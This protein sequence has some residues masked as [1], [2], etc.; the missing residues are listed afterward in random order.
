MKYLS[1]AVKEILATDDIAHYYLVKMG[2]FKNAD[3]DTETM[4]HTHVSGGITIGD[5]YY[6][7]DNTLTHVDPPRQSAAVDRENFKIMYSDPEFLYRGLFEKGFSG[8]PVEIYIGFFNTLG[9]ALGGPKVN[10]I[11]PTGVGAGEPLENKMDLVTVYVGASDT[12]TYNIDM[13]GDITASIEC[14]S[15]MGALGMVRTLL[16]SKER[17][18]SQNPTDSSYDQIYIGSAGL[19]LLWGKVT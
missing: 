4:F 5:D 7:D 16:T 1:D 13:D 10:G 17:L 14:T 18:R 3:G 8:V 6:S 11:Y 2:P 12:P 9:K 15:P 19:D